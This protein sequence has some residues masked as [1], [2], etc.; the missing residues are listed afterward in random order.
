MDGRV[1]RGDS[2][3]G[4]RGLGRGRVGTRPQKGTGTVGGRGRPPDF[5]D[6]DEKGWSGQSW[7]SGLDER[8]LSDALPVTLR[9]K[10]VLSRPS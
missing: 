10:I 3:P 1:G 5:V 8:A 6:L 7:F 4:H 9:R 2:I